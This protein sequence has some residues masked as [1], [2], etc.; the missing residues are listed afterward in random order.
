MSHRRYL[1]YGCALTGGGFGAAGRCLVQTGAESC[2]GT[3]AVG[4]LGVEVYA[5]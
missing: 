5:P 3:V 1:S 2:C 4:L